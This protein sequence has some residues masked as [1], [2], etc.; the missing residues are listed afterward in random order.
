M[1]DKKEMGKL[2]GIYDLKGL[3]YPESKESEYPAIMVF[4][5]LFIGGFNSSE[6][7]F[8]NLTKSTLTK[9]LKNFIVYSNLIDPLFLLGN[10]RFL[11]RLFGVEEA[12]EQIRAYLKN[13]YIIKNEKLIPALREL[14]D[15]I[16]SITQTEKRVISEL[17]DFLTK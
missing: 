10:V 3:M 4:L 12:K 2:H 8:Y 17:I 9:I 1:I 7:A 6:R 14:P 11:T 16:P 15:Y 5:D 13:P